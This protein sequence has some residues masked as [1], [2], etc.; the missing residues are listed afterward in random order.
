M[1]HNMPLNISYKKF[2]GFYQSALHD[3][4]VTTGITDEYIAWYVFSIIIRKK[5]L[6]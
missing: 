5:M 1:A 4:N 3:E 2:S 6:L